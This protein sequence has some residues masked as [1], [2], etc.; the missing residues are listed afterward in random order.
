LAL[1]LALGSLVYQRAQSG[2]ELRSDSRDAMARGLPTTAL[3]KANAA[4][5]S[6]MLSARIWTNLAQTQEAVGQ[7]ARATYERVTRLQPTRGLNWLDNAEYGLNKRGLKESQWLETQ[8]YTAIMYDPNDP[9]IRMARGDWLLKNGDKR[10]WKDYEF[11][12]SLAEKPYGKYPATPEIV[13]LNFARAYA[14]LA[15]RDAQ[16][17]QFSSAQKYVERG[18]QE[19]ATAR[20]YEPSRRAMETATYGAPDEKRAQELD[21]LE[22]NLKSLREKLKT[23]RIKNG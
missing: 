19:I 22:T 7:D 20:E 16:R 10:G 17:K 2:E 12:A 8:F 1:P 11:I 3:E 21:E 6:D 23:E 4:K 14:K 15:A 9:Q 18:L 13:D 5:E